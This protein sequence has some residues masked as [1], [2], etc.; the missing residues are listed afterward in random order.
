MQQVDEVLRLKVQPGLKRTFSDSESDTIATR[1][2]QYYWHIL[3]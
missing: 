3:H 1:L 2:T